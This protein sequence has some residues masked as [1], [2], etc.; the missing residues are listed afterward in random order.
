MLHTA[1]PS[2]TDENIHYFYV[3]KKNRKLALTL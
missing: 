1:D 3:K 2:L